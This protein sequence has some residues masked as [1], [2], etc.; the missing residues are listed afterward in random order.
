MTV[1]PAAPLPDSAWYEPRQRY[2]AD[3]LVN[4]LD[5]TT[6]RDIAHVMGVTSRD[7]SVTNG[8]IPDSS[9]TARTAAA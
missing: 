1:F 5:R 7:I 4:F 2:R 3:K 8:R 9:C 6:S